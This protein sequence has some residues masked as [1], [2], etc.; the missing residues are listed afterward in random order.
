[1]TS[2]KIIREQYIGQM[3]NANPDQKKVNQ[4]KLMEQLFL[5]E[6]WNNADIIGVTIS[7]PMELDT[8][9]IIKRAQS[10]GKQIVIPRTLP[11]RQMEFVELTDKTEFAVKFHIDEPVNGT[12]IAKHNI[13]LMLVPGVAFAENGYRIGFGGGYYDRYLA[14][15]END[16]ISLCL[17]EQRIPTEII[18]QYIDPF[19][20]KIKQ[21]LMSQGGRND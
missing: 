10:E 6:Q 1:M 19:D 21:V 7:S 3:M 8:D 2:K 16:T 9:T 11:K 15:F 12:V 4:Q 14:D 17:D 20:I 5:S 13:N 18:N